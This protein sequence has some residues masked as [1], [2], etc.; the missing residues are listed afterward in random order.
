MGKVSFRD[1]RRV[2]D[3]EKK[4][5]RGWIQRRISKWEMRIVERIL[6]RIGI[7]GARILDIPCGYGRFSDIIQK[8]GATFIA[9][10]ISRDMVIRAAAMSFPR[11]LEPSESAGYLVADASQIPLADKS[12]DGAISIRL[13][14]HLFDSTLRVRSLREFGR[15]SRRFVIL[16]FY[17][18]G[19]LHSLQRLIKRKTKYTRKHIEF[20]SHFQFRSE[21]E[22][23]GLNLLGVFPLRHLFHA[24]CF[25]LLMPRKSD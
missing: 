21:A 18:R 16:T 9:G 25:A 19:G 24:Q 15:V 5:Y 6:K 12:V 1:D 10:D 22:A 4:R 11:R 13:F 8:C 17:E 7:G 14:Q 23:A 20:L 3:Y 2:C